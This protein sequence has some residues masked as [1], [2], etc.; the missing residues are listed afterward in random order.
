M[1]NPQDYQSIKDQCI[2]GGSL[3]EDDSF[4]ASNASIYYDGRDAQV[5]WKR[6]AEICENPMFAQ[7]GAT[8]FD[9]DQGD[10][11][12]CWFLSAAGTIALNPDLF[13]RVV[14]IDQTFTEGYAGI[15]RF[16]FWRYGVWTEVVVDDRLPTKNNRL[17]FCRNRESLNEFWSALLEKAYAK[18]F[19]S[20]QALETGFSHEALVDMTG[21]IGEFID[22]KNIPDRSKFFKL[23]KRLHKRG[24]LICSA[25]ETGDDGTYESRLDNGLVTGHAY[26]LTNISEV[27]V[28]EAKVQL[29]RLRNP[30]GFKEWNGAWSD[31]SEEWT[32]LSEEQRQTFDLTVDNDGEFWITLGDWLDNFHTVQIC[33][34]TPDTVKGGGGRCEWSVSAFHG[35]WLPGVTAGGC[36]APPNQS[37]YWLNPQ[38]FIRLTD[39]D[40]DDDEELCTLV[41]SLVQKFTR[42]RKTFEKTDDTQGAI[43]YD[44]YRVRN[45]AVELEG[46][47]VGQSAL[48][49][50]QKMFNYEFLRERSG[51]LRL[52]PG[53][54]CVIPCSYSPDDQGEFMLRLATE[55][56]AAS[57]E[58]DGETSVE[59]PSSSQLRGRKFDRLFT[60]HSG[61]DEVVDAREL[62]RILNQGREA[63]E[64]SRET[65]RALIQSVTGDRRGKLDKADT[66]SIWRKVKEYE[67]VFNEFDKD[68][69]GIL[70]SRE[71]RNAFRS[72][73][74]RMSKRALGRIVERYC[75]KEN[76]LTLDEFVLCATKVVN[77]NE[78]FQAA[79]TRS[80]N[81][82]ELTLDELLEI[83]L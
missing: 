11:G 41:V 66:K 25:I 44:V 28:N 35:A 10:L 38:Y 70:D 43:G 79:R 6:P 82:V 2:E 22:V 71:L 14:P 69:S 48:R 56:P 58:V 23:I 52:D 74:F 9:L 7:D 50:E 16:N 61:D 37:A 26:S 27:T 18:I 8:I 60:Q 29:V 3:F 63:N 64:F 68:N 12:N 5:E 83:T 33:H 80:G 76:N 62:T 51:R 78:S 13:A 45:D 17:V 40:E 21:G 24:S 1:S 54:Y 47:H 32:S 15:F 73:G 34:M 31:S 36:G 49:V 19:G 57:G 20:Y 67:G 65:S 75:G 59:E 46:L 42:R 81:K 53:T 72:L 77:T 55:R 39:P 30:W 4:P